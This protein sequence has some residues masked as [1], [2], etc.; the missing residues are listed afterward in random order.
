MKPMGRIVTIVNPMGKLDEGYRHNVTIHFE[1]VRR[2]K[3]T[4][5]AVRT[6]V[7]RR[8]LVPLVEEVLPLEEAALAHR[9]LE[10][11]GVKGKL[12]LKIP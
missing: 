9:R 5:D 3:H 1:F 7:E 8:L 11:G 4:L 2:N 10:A 12:V 6:L